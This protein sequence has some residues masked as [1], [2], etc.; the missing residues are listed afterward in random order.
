MPSVNGTPL[1]PVQGLLDPNRYVYRPEMGNSGLLDDKQYGNLIQNFAGG[2]L[3]GYQESST[4]NEQGQYF[5]PIAP[6]G[7]YTTDQSKGTTVTDE[8]PTAL[9]NKDA[10]TFMLGSKVGGDHTRG[11]DEQMYYANL[12]LGEVGLEKA[13]QDAYRKNFLNGVDLDAAYDPTD[14]KWKKMMQSFGAMN[15][16]RSGGGDGGG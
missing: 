7:V 15:N 13:T 10:L 1:Y 12:L 6:S 2:L 5:T 16:T 11:H 8:K 14:P 3:N 9:T 4:P